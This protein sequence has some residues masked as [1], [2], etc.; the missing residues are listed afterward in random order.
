MFAS[1]TVVAKWLYSSP[2]LTLKRNQ[3]TKRTNSF[4]LCKDRKSLITG[5]SILWAI[6]S[7]TVGNLVENIT[8]TGWLFSFLSDNLLYWVA[9]HVHKLLVNVYI[10]KVLI[11]DRS[12]F[13]MS[14][15]YYN[16]CIY[17]CVCISTVVQYAW[18]YLYRFIFEIAM[19]VTLKHSCWT[20]ELKLCLQTMLKKHVQGPK[21]FACVSSYNHDIWPHL[22]RHFRH[23]EHLFWWRHQ[24]MCIHCSGVRPI[25]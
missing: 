15:Y 5:I 11:D 17:L 16:L 9:F 20:C 19:S 3:S 4:N 23:T 6:F 8:Y 24:I 12:S 1:M 2:W 25:E 22:W 13:G 18:S 21:Q 14:V 10:Y 7:S